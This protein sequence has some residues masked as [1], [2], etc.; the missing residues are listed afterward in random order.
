MAQN[1]SGKYAIHKFEKGMFAKLKIPVPDRPASG[2]HTYIVVKLIENQGNAFRM[3]TEY[4]I[5]SRCYGPRQL[6]PINTSMYD[7]YRNKIG[8]NN[9]KVT[10]RKAAKLLQNLPRVSIRCGCKVLP[11]AAN[12]KCKKSNVKCTKFCHGRN[13]VGACDNVAEGTAFNEMA[14]VDAGA[15]SDG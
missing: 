13:P 9:T 10:L 1:H 14:V 5:L 6:A 8:S 12:C 11:C 4:G 3:Q 15:I 2:G 7:Y